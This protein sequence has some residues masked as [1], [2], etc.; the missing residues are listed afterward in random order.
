MKIVRGNINSSNNDGVDNV[1]RD[2]DEVGSV[3]ASV[4]SLLI[5]HVLAAALE[6]KA[7]ITEHMFGNGTTKAYLSNVLFEMDDD[8]DIEEM[9]NSLQSSNDSVGDGDEEVGMEDQSMNAN[10][11]G[12]IDPDLILTANNNKF[13]NINLLYFSCK[14]CAFILSYFYHFYQQCFDKCI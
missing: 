6:E 7:Q 4:D 10:L 2:C 14:S 12:K 11:I 8:S 3:L 13:I 9:E 5:D 1:P